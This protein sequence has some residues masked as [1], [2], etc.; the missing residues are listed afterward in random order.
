MLRLTI[1]LALAAVAFAKYDHCCSAADRHVVQ[2]EWHELWNDVESSRMKIGFG[3]L[4]ML[5]LVEM[6][7][8]LKEPLKVV[9]IDHPNSGLFSAYSLRILLALDNIITLLDDPEALDAATD[10]MA[11]RWSS[12][13]AVTVDHFRDFAKIVGKG[14]AKLA[15]NYD[16]MSWKTCFTGIMKKITS[17][18]HT[19]TTDEVAHHSRR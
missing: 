16:P 12:K 18:L 10:Y 19:G 4:A 7:P 3:R 8:E 9:D 11:R 1:L 13:E 2:E 14:V 6:H 17:H 15:H 5:K